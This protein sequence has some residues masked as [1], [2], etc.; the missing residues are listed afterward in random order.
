MAEVYE[1]QRFCQEPTNRPF[2]AA[3]QSCVEANK[4]QPQRSGFYVRWCRNSLIFSRI[5]SCGIAQQPI[6][7]SS[8]AF[9]QSSAAQ[10]PSSPANSASSFTIARR[11]SRLNCP[12]ASPYR[13][14]RFIKKMT[15]S[16]LSLPV[17]L[18]A[19]DD[20]PCSTIFFDGGVLSAFGR[21]SALHGIEVETEPEIRS[22]SGKISLKA[23][24][25]GI[26][27]WSLGSMVR[28]GRRPRVWEMSV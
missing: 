15:T 9:C 2:G 17:L 18:K 24:F 21:K 25:E 3:Y 11:N 20:N 14:N 13:S 22:W 1:F 16:L 23:P 26:G 19:S 27:C 12:G 7:C 28:V 10:P 5:R 8:Y 4:V 6:S